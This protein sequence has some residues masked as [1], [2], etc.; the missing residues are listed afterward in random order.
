MP[1]LRIHRLSLAF[2][3]LIF[4]YVKREEERKAEV[5][6]KDFRYPTADE[7]YALEKWAHRE[8]AK[9]QA[10]L[11]KAAFSWM[12]KS[13]RRVLAPSARTV[14]KHAAHHA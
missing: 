10:A 5:E 13:I 14:Q 3:G 12:N 7:L 2:H 11:L 9:A 6:M 1:S 4:Q 8:R